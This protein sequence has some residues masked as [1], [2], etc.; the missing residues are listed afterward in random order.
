[1][2][3]THAKAV[4]I[5]N[6]AIL[7]PYIEKWA[8]LKDPLDKGPITKSTYPIKEPSQLRTV[9]TALNDSFVNQA[10]LSLD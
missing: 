6:F 5:P 9:I 3:H 10:S 4:E 1:M 7:G 8:T 2:V